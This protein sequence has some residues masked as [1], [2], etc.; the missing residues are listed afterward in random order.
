MLCA[1]LLR[2]EQFYDSV[3][4][5]LGYQCRSIGLII[6]GQFDSC[7]DATAWDAVMS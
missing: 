4:G 2:V 1:T 6:S 5:L 3:G 7:I